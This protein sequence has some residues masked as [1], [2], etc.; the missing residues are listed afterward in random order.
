[1]NSTITIQYFEYKFVLSK[2]T[3]FTKVCNIFV[4]ISVRSVLIYLYSI[5]KYL[6]QILVIE[7]T[8]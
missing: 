3:F 8:R 4:F 5:Y 1:M 6:V 2:T 7:D